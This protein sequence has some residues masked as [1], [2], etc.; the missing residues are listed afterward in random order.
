MKIQRW[1]SNHFFE[2]YARPTGAV[3]TCLRPIF[4]PWFSAVTWLTH[5]PA[6]KNVFQDWFILD[7]P[8]NSRKSQVWFLLPS[9]CGR[10]KQHHVTSLNKSCLRC[11]VEGGSWCPIVTRS[12]LH[13]QLMLRW[14]NPGWLWEHLG[15]WWT[16]FV[17]LIWDAYL[18]TWIY[19]GLILSLF[20]FGWGGGAGFCPGFCWG[21][22]CKD[23]G[24]GRFSIFFVT[25]LY[26]THHM[27]S[28]ANKNYI[29]HHQ[30]SE[31]KSFLLPCHF[32]GL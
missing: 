32:L 4:L 18:G 14:I 2:E 26:Y 22:V 21:V 16:F 13:L 10:K 29:I 30:T 17:G 7:A 8:P 24:F 12:P 1:K 19:F 31:K 28:W 5:A 20:F 3:A 6:G 27:K 23:C 9:F 15:I 25:S 11:A